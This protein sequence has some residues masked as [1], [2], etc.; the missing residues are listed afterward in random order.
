MQVGCAIHA[1]LV[2]MGATALAVNSTLLTA[3][4]CFAMA[5]QVSS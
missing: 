1:P 3:I 5:A 2:V 4:V